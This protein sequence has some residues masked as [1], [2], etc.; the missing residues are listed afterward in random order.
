MVSLLQPPSVAHRLAP[1]SVPVVDLL[2]VEAGEPPGVMGFEV[3]SVPS[4]FF[5]VQTILSDSIA[6]RGL[7]SNTWK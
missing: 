6:G 3:K 1:L 7:L 4:L 5:V 2:E